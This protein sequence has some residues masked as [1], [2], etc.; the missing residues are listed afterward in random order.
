MNEPATR[1]TSSSSQSIITYTHTHTLTQH[2]H[3]ESLISP[4][5]LFHGFPLVTFCSSSNTHGASL[6]RSR[7][8]GRGKK[9]EG[10]NSADCIRP[11]YTYAH[12]HTCIIV[13]AARWAPMQIEPRGLC[14]PSPG[15]VGVTTH[16]CMYVC[17]YVYMYVCMYVWLLLLL[18]QNWS[19]KRLC[20]SS[21]T[22]LDGAGFYF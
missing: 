1:L 22:A 11:V 13:R 19:R 5:K 15:V 10:N 16:V 7:C 3:T 9:P 4:L 8:R 17:M 20:T 12:V 2:T 14:W 18:G 6:S 21:Q